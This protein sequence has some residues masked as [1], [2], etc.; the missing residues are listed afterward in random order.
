MAKTGH[1][2]IP[3]D[4][5]DSSLDLKTIIGNSYFDRINFVFFNRNVRNHLG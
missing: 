5:V 1:R 4:S 2:K 3:S